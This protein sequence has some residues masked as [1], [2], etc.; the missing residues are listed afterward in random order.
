MKKILVPVD[1][2]KTSFAAFNY[3]VNLAKKLDC[4]I[5]LIHIIYGSLTTHEFIGINPLLSMEESAHK[6]ME[7]FTKD[8][9]AEVGIKLPEVPIKKEVRFGLAG[10]GIA[11]YANDY[12]FDL[13]IMGTRD[14]HDLFDRFL[15]SASS[16]VIRK[17]D[18]PVMLIHENTPYV[19]PK[20]IAFAFDTKVDLSDSIEDFLS[21]N[22]KLKAK[23]DFVHVDENANTVFN[24]KEEIVK[25]LFEENE[26]EFVFEIKNILGKDVQSELQDYCIFEKADLL[27]MVLRD[28]GLFSRMFRSTNSIK[29]AQDFH[30]PVI[31]FHED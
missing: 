17:A 30:L 18:C 14:K 23:T 13:V 11:N 31:I 12:D 19:E 2:Y 5:T 8:Y 10:F 6:R 20:K 4:E 22:Q 7:Y 27:A 9:P 29:M 3:A 21:I 16:I 24:K 26:P 1:F 25:E 15:G 28:D